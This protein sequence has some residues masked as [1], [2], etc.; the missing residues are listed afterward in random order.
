MNC[1]AI[2]PARGGSKG[3]PRKNILPLG[4]KPV[5]RWT[6]E[7]AL[8]A[9]A[10]SDVVV[11]T[12]SQEIAAIAVAAGAQVPFMRPPALAGDDTPMIETVLH[13]ISEFER[14]SG[15]TYEAFALLQPTCP[16]RNS[17]DI[18]GS[19]D[20][21]MQSGADSVI[22]MHKLDSGHPH[23]IYTLDGDRPALLVPP[24]RGVTRRQDYMPAYLRNGL[25]Y[26]TR[27]N[28]LLGDK[29]FYGRD[30]RAYITDPQRSVNIDTPFDFAQAEFI[31]GYRAAS[32]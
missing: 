30:V 31:A 22:T 11:T 1:L 19:L 21:L 15:K 32:L 9:R 3:L 20:L 18:D 26:A 16:F 17:A 23:Y 24:P 8:G 10:V 14:M 7:A 6:I 12:D 25:V 4:G 5:I 13:A 27:R 29:D 28:T 2:V